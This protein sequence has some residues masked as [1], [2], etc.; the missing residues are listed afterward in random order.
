M[1]NL[2]QIFFIL[3]MRAVVFGMTPQTCLLGDGQKVQLSLTI[4]GRRICRRLGSQS[5]EMVPDIVERRPV[6][7]H[8]LH[9]HQIGGFVHIYEATLFAKPGRVTKLAFRIMILFFIHES[10][11]SQGMQGA[12]PLVMLFDMAPDARALT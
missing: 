2:N 9:V 12:A 10:L 6:A 7:L 8:T 4:A 5:F 11:P 3:K 1:F